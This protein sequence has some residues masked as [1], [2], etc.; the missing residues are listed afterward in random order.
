M[1]EI[2]N[3]LAA[4]TVQIGIHLTLYTSYTNQLN[5]PHPM[6]LDSHVY[7]HGIRVVELFGV[8]GHDS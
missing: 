2:V 7:V 4:H 8:K 5:L 3:K 1:E 6:S